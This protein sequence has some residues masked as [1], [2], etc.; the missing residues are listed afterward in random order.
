ME[1]SFWIIVV[2]NILMYIEGAVVGFVAGTA[3]QQTK[4]TLIASVLFWPIALPL[5]SYKLYKNYWPLVA[6]LLPL[7][8]G[9]NESGDES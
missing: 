4:P 5:I 2:I 1:L 6:N 7:L 3:L 8:A 9:N